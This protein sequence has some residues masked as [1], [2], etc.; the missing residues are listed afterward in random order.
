MKDYGRNAYHHILI[1]ATVPVLST[2]AILFDSIWLG[3][4]T[5]GLCFFKLLYVY[6]YT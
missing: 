4:G 6:M 3:L 5:V 1:S 2:F